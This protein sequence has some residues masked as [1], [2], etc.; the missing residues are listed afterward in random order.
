MIEN[1]KK[2]INLKAIFKQ[3]LFPKG[4]NEEDDDYKIIKYEV[5]E[6]YK[7]PSGSSEIVVKG[8]ALPEHYGVE[9]V[10]SLVQ[11]NAS[12]NSF[13]C[14]NFIIDIP[15]TEKAIRQ[16]LTKD[17][18]VFKEEK[19]NLLYSIYKE[20]LLF[21]LITSGPAYNDKSLNMQNKEAIKDLQ[22][23]VINS[24]V[25]SVLTKYGITNIDSSDLYN[26]YN[27][28]VLQI[29][30]SD[31][32]VLVLDNFIGF[33]NAEDLIKS[34]NASKK[35]KSRLLS[36]GIEVIKQNEKSGNSCI[37]YKD[38]IK[39]MIFLLD[40][41]QKNKNYEFIAQKTF[42]LLQND[43]KI[44]VYQKDKELYIYSSYAWKAET[45]LSHNIFKFSSYKGKVI[46][47]I[48]RMIDSKEVEFGFKLAPEQREA[49][50]K[51]LVNKITIITGGP[52]TGKTSVINFIRS[53]A[54]EINKSSNILLCAPTGMAARRMTESTGYAA[55]TMHSAMNIKPPEEGSYIEIKDFNKLEGYDLIIVDEFSM[56]DMYLADA[57]FRALDTKN[58]VPSIVI[59]GDINQLPSVGAGNVLSDLIYSGKINSIRLSQVYR[60]KNESF[61]AVNAKHICSGHE[62][63]DYGKGFS[64]IEEKTD[65][66]TINSIKEIYAKSIN[67]YGVDNVCVLVPFK[68]KKSYTNIS[69]EGINSK[70]QE[71]ANLSNS[72]AY[73]FYGKIYKQGDKVIQIKTQDNIANGDIG[74][75]SSIS[76][77]NN[78]IKI[79]IDFGDLGEVEY[80]KKDMK[81]VDLAYSVT[82]HKSQ[83]S[84]YKVVIMALTDEHKPML[85]RNL[86]YTG[87]TRAK[88]ELYIVGS[89]NALSSSIRNKSKEERCTFLSQRIREKQ[90]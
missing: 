42:S 29:I 61:I 73:R 40:F 69:T 34:Y 33:K 9:I 83:G 62:K 12:E 27:I 39:N 24:F 1:N 84:E 37:A 81:F 87:I 43:G 79:K 21:D 36:I 74:V 49:V 7:S 85:K 19:Y 78:Q 54:K 53:L 38:A 72:K 13:F 88:D 67:K 63:L 3:K 6:G 70:L 15:K 28:Q 82:I 20:R 41:A 89:K 75:I 22:K 76:E 45:T 66:D 80:D 65:E 47:N 4:N 50:R 86:T 10:F 71:V 55:Y 90:N 17:C 44:R 57:F 59:I 64:L 31:P 68:N 48:E 58:K 5:T 18:N 26:K 52:G 11:D 23:L 77:E 14:N 32:H 51:A 56:V 16:V 35:T 30:K 2:V 46:K 8:N 60:Q 25:Q